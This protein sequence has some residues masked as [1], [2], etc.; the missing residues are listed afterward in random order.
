MTSNLIWTRITEELAIARTRALLWCPVFLAFGI[1]LF[2]NMKSEPSKG[3]LISIF[4]SAIALLFLGHGASNRTQSLLWITAVISLGFSVAGMRTHTVAAPVLG[5]HYYGVVEGRIIGIDRSGSNKPRLT[6]DQVKMGKIS[7]RRTP[8]RVRISLHAKGDKYLPKPND[9]IRV[10]ANMNKPGGPVEPS[11]FDFQR[12]S[13]FRGLGAVG[14]SRKPVELITTAPVADFNAWVF[15]IRIAISA[16][17]KAGVGGQAGAFAAA[18]LTGDRSDVDP[19]NLTAL[20][21]SNLAH[22]LAISGLHMGLLTGVVLAA[23]RSAG[24]LIPRVALRAPIKKWAAIIACFAGLCYLILSGAST[25]TQRAFIMVAMMLG[26]ILLDRPALSLRAV[27]MAAIII[28]TLWPEN[29]LQPGFQM[30]FAA[31]IALIVTFQG[32]KDLPLLAIMRTGRLRYAQWFFALL[33]S[34][35]VAGAATAPFAAYHFNQVAHYGLLANIISV[36]VMGLV[37]MPMAVLAGVLYPIGLDWL[38]FWAM[39]LGIDWILWVA[40][41]VSGWNGAISRVPNAPAVSLFLIAIGGVIFALMTVPMRKV[42]VCLWI[43]GL[44]SWTWADRPMVLVSQDG[45]LVG[46]N[47]AQGRVLN[48]SK[49]SGFAARNWLEN[50]GDLRSQKSAALNLGNH[51][52]VMDGPQIVEYA[53]NTKM[54]DDEL[55]TLC[56]KADLVLAPKWE[57]DAPLNCQVFGLEQFYDTGAISIDLKNGALHIKSARHFHGKR[58]WNSHARRRLRKKKD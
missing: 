18:I 45:R 38:A 53:W 12:Y 47:S 6:L 4:A 8:T 14:Y 1:F 41:T 23:V 3:M 25:A 55:A 57:G 35:F 31:T 17:I 27:A 51:M 21:Q 20:R 52:T 28:L 26:A 56:S 42:S 7:Q 13:W 22:L 32:L 30:S 11:G 54:T 49:G 58:I 2:F 19:S 39:G 9:L 44:V 10:T 33:V 5:W 43:V 34:S 29:L 50:D 36:P 40:N 16:Q 46:I 37:V 24:A 48:R 15:R